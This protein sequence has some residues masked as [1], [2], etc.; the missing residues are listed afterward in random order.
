MLKMLN[1]EKFGTGFYV[2]DSEVAANIEFHSRCIP[3]VPM[4]AYTK[5]DKCQKCFLY[6]F[7]HQNVIQIHS[8]IYSL[9][10]TFIYLIVY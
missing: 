2:Q 1:F 3:K 8:I 6:K 10:D 7:H 5:C 4:G 9:T